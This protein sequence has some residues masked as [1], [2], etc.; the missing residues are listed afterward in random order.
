MVQYGGG[1]EAY[2]KDTVWWKHE[3]L[4]YADA[5]VLI[6]DSHTKS[7]ISKIKEKDS[8]CDEDRILGCIQE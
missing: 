4:R 6:P 8:P 1:Q 3:Q 7:K 2:K 5:T